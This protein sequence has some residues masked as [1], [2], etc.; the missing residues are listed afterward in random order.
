M[1]KRGLFILVILSFSFLHAQKLIEPDTISTY[2]RYMDEVLRPL[3][4]SEE[5]QIPNKILYD[6]VVPFAH[7][8]KFNDSIKTATSELFK[9]AWEELFDAS[10][11]KDFSPVDVVEKIAYHYERH[12]TI[13][14]GLIDMDLGKIK[15]NALDSLNPSLQIINKRIHKISGKNPFVSRHV[16]MLAP[17]NE[18]KVKGPNVTFG[19]GIIRLLKS[20]KHI[21][22]ITASF[23]KNQTV[24]LMKNRP[25]PVGQNFVYYQ[26]GIV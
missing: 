19:F 25:L 26:G 24:T 3:I 17:L 20:T 13:L 6:R 9:R 18:E 22:R 21:Q 14:I 16:T 10:L 5:N 12:D 2:T 4:Q 8:D 23:D 1:K 11:D 15:D 7:L